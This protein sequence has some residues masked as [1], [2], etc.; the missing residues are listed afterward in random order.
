MRDAFLQD[1]RENPDDDAPRLVFADWLEDNG[2]PQRADFI[3]VQCALASMLDDGPRRI[4]LGAREE[5]LLEANALAWTEGAFLAWLEHDEQDCPTEEDHS[6]CETFA[7][8]TRLRLAVRDPADASRLEERLKQLGEERKLPLIFAWEL[9]RPFFTEWEFARGFL[10]DVAIEEVLF[11][12]FAPAVRDLGMVRELTLMA[13]EMEPEI[14]DDVISRLIDHL[15]E[16]PLQ[17][18]HLGTM[19]TNDEEGIKE[20]VNWPGMSQVRRLTALD[21]GGD[22]QADAVLYVVSESPYLRNLEHLQLL[23]SD[24]YTDAGIEL[25][26]SSPNLPRLQKVQLYCDDHNLS[27][28]VLARFIARFGVPHPDDRS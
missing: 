16:P 12:L 14:G 22:S 11:Y 13:D 15:G 3:R 5:E 4:E 8:A 28:S 2:D 24:A 20:L 26:L 21:C 6:V 10:H 1:I 7:E 25:L 19:T 27:V 23:F 17:V 18:L 9:R